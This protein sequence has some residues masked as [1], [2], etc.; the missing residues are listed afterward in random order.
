[1]QSRIA[2][3]F[4][5]HKKAGEIMALAESI[6]AGDFQYPQSNQPLAID[7]AVELIAQNARAH[8][9]ERL[10]N[11]SG[12]TSPDHNEHLFKKAIKRLALDSEGQKLSAEEFSKNI[13]AIYGAVFT[14]HPVT[15]KTVEEGVSIANAAFVRASGA[16]AQ[17]ISDADAALE[18]AAEI[19]FEKPTLA[20]ESANSIQAITS[21][22]EARAKMAR[23][24]MQVGQELYG[25]EWNKIDYMPTT[26]ATWIPFDWDGRTDVEPKD[27]MHRRIE[28]QTLM[29]D[30]YA[31]RFK[32]LQVSLTD[33]ADKET[34]K[35]LVEHI[36][37]T[38]E[39]MSE[40]QVFF[41]NYDAKADTDS[42]ILRGKYEQFKKDSQWRL[43]DPNDLI[44]PLNGILSKTNADQLHLQEQLVHLR[45]DLRNDGLSFAQVHFRLNAKSLSSALGEHGLFIDPEKKPEQADATYFD[46]LSSM[47]DAA[48]AKDFDLIQTMNA[49]QTV[50]KQMGMI[51][52][53]DKYVEQGRNIRFL[54]AETDKAITPLTALYFAKQFGIENKISISGLCED[55]EGQNEFKRLSQLLIT[56]QSYREHIFNGREYHPFKMSMEAD[57]F[58]FSDSHRYDGAIAAGAHMG[59]A[60]GQKEKVLAEAMSDMSDKPSL[61]LTN[62]GT[63]GQSMNR[64]FHPLGPAHDAQYKLAPHVLKKADDDGIKVTLETSFQGMDGNI[65]MLN[66]D[67][68]F[69]YMTKSID[70][71]TDKN[72]HKTLSNDPF[73]DKNGLRQDVFEFFETARNTHENLINK[74]GY[75]IVIDQFVRSI[76]S[77]GSRPVKRPKDSGG[78]R[79]LPRAIQHGGTLSRLS[80]WSTVMDGIGAAIL[81]NED[82]F[83]R[84]RESGVFNNQF[85]VTVRSALKETVEGVVRAEVELYNPKFW[86]ER[87][88]HSESS[89]EQE[90]Y[91]AV[92][93]HLSRLGLYNNMISVVEQMEQNAKNLSRVFKDRGLLLKEK[94]ATASFN[95]E[96]IHG[97]RISSMMGI[98]EKAMNVPAI[99]ED[100]HDNLTRNQVIDRLFM[101]D[102][103]VLDDLKGKVFQNHS[104]FGYTQLHKDVLDPIGDDMDRLQIKT[105]LPLVD[106]NGAVG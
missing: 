18:E 71:L 9:V 47:V 5:K 59:R 94:N 100:K 24:A 77:T 29:L 37:K 68:A 81:E 66:P 34:V 40:Y 75:P 52:E 43:S 31:E 95:K 7:Q 14:G 55:R 84:L 11:Y 62:F 82:R 91:R 57:Q 61:H 88:K 23:L 25:E 80:M 105:A 38:H 2:G 21:A 49:K 51:S 32:K 89:N 102:K 50:V 65:Y 16:D 101:F 45:S 10:A 54:I 28:L 103:T 86:E 12:D 106:Y 70:Y 74:R 15:S 72:L 3:H 69:S 73:Y 79:D 63:G 60:M 53:F 17:A 20:K 67:M 99:P 35:S 87:A 39:N 26:I 8:R 64:G 93:S 83:D 56:N 76:T 97:A 33:A 36:E 98:F 27:I 4:G 1:M 6:K 41:E 22:R 46:Q 104:E 96:V 19:P 30:E 85:L 42:S 92:A 90:K 44:E 58:G 78:E 13:Y 48:N